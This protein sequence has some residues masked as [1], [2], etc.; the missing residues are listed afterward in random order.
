MTLAKFGTRRKK[1]LEK[2]EVRGWFIKL[3]DGR[4]RSYER[5]SS[6]SGVYLAFGLCVK[7][8]EGSNPQF[9]DTAQSRQLMKQTISKTDTWYF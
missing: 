2:L 5:F 3:A 8:T 6:V 7:C 1:D 4:A 9:I